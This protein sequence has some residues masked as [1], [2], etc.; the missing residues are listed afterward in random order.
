MRF[1][2]ADIPGVLVIDAEPQ[3]DERGWFM[4][5]WCTREFAAA[6]IPGPMVQTS[7]SCSRRRGTL[8]GLHFQLPPSREGKLVRCVQGELHDVL[9]DLRCES[10]T[11]LHSFAM[12]LSGG[13]P[14]AVYVPP[15]VAHGFQTLTDD[16][17]VLY[18]MTD[19]YRPDL[20]TGVRW[21]DPALNL[22]WPL[23]PTVLSAR[24][25]NH[26]DLDVQH[27]QAFRGY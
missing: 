10:P 9:V 6:G 25:R 2:A 23:Q 16:T 13:G 8:R 4:R 22:R 19:E 14:A 27:F 7:L 11:W 1:T 3:G 5:V 20:S 24:D 15:G 12:R 18:Q 21:N 26:P 17:Q